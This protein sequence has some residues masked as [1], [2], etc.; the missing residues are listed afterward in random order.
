LRSRGLSFLNVKYRPL[1]DIFV[2]ITPKSIRNTFRCILARYKLVRT[3]DPMLYFV[4]I[5]FPG[6][7]LNNHY[8]PD[9]IPVFFIKRLRRLIVQFNSEPNWNKLHYLQS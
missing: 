2:Y 5:C 7:A 3:G 4:T 8:F 9:H 1:A 6:F